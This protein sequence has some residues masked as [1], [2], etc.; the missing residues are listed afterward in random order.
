LKNLPKLILPSPFKAFAFGFR[1]GNDCPKKVTNPSLVNAS[2]KGHFEGMVWAQRTSIPLELHSKTLNH[3]SANSMSITKHENYNQ[4]KYHQ[5]RFNPKKL[6]FLAEAG[7]VSASILSRARDPLRMVLPEEE[8]PTESMAFGSMVDML[9]LTPEDW[10][11]YYIQ[12]SSQAPKKPSSAQLKA[13][14]KGTASQPSLNAISFWRAWEQKSLGKTTYDSTLMEKVRKSAS[15][16]KMHPQAQYIHEHS[17]KQIVL[18]G[19]IPGNCLKAG[20]K[21]KCMIDLLPR[22]GEL[23]T[24]DGSRLQLNE[25]VVDLKTSHSVSEH[26]M[27]TAIHNFEYHMKMAWYLR[28]LHGAGETQRD[29]AILIFQNSKHPRDVH[30]RLIDPEDMAAGASLAQQRLDRL[31]QLNSERIHEL[32]DNE[33]KVISRETWMKKEE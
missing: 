4:I 33:F 20:G 13:A 28:M 19:D 10:N 2:P 9:W 15:M 16:L 31:C 12:L 24:A 29:K 32:F 17:D 21:A 25:C 5:Q 3:T 22:D 7:P 6:P 26:G 27:R 8:A 23:E 30:V 18:Q 1:P 14:D 11:E